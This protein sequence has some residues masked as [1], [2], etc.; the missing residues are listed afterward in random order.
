M[1]AVAAADRER[2]LKASLWLI[3]GGIAAVA[4]TTMSL[5]L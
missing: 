2:S 5:L 3:G 1:A 4:S